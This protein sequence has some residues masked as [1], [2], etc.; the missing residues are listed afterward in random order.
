VTRW[1]AVVGI[2]EDGLA[3]LSTAGRTLV[4][5]AEFLVGGVR[6]LA[7]APPTGTT[8]RLVW[9]RPISDTIAAIAALRGRRVV[10][11]ASGDPLWYGIGTSLLRHFAPEE[12]TILPQPSVFS[13]AAA[14]LGWPLADCTAISLH[15]RPL[16]TLR[17][18][19][20]PG[21]RVL[22]LSADRNT[23]SAVAA[24]LTGLGWGPSR[25]TV[26]NHL[27][28]PHQSVV[29]AE[30]QCWGD[31]PVA[32]LNTI[33]LECRP[34][35]GARAFSRLA[36]LPDDAFEH[37]GQLT[38]REVRAASLAALGPLCGETLWDIGAG[39]GSIAV[40]WL[41]AGESCLAIAVERDMT[42]AA[43][44]AR[45]AARLG[46]PGLRIVRGTAPEAIA[47]L[48]VPDAIFVGGGI[49]APGLLPGLWEALRPGGRLV[50]NVV[51]V[52]GEARLLDWHRRHGGRLT[53]IAVSRAEPAHGHHLWRPLAN[54]TQLTAIKPA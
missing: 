1:L 16:D 32:D 10:V 13:L 39:C 47:G 31:R 45:N 9:Q 27:G 34:Q 19:L 28:G 29:S 22:A 23:P 15:A 54:V 30:A 41:R 40:E 14:H 50:A 37:D 7:L 52:V 6:H 4:E 48:P 42:R 53:R 25:L 46:V 36:G 21:R 43:M 44:I 12:M 2:G 17:L 49:G 51:T 38:K 5:T 11:L 18:H 24:L 26:L 33:A 35:A 3:G 8:E 20:L